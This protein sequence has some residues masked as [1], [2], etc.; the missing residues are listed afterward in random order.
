MWQ[1]D[2]AS[3]TVA[4][5]A[6]AAATPFLRFYLS[7]QLPGKFFI[8]DASSTAIAAT[9][10]AAVVAVVASTLCARLLGR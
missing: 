3:S 9:T 2:V 8:G 7:L 10:A 5:A 1:R 6:A 4:A